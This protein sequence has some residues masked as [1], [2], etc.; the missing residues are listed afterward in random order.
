MAKLYLFPIQK[1]SAALAKQY[2]EQICDEMRSNHLVFGNKYLESVE[3]I[4]I[5]TINQTRFIKIHPELPSAFQAS[6]FGNPAI[7][8]KDL[9]SVVTSILDK[10]KIKYEEHFEFPLK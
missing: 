4:N 8:T 1:Q 6:N 7:N 5:S 10:Y 3:I 9:V 2:S